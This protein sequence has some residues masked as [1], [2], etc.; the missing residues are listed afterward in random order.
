MDLGG[1]CGGCVGRGLGEDLELLLKRHN[2]LVAR[3]HGLLELSNGLCVT[4]S[5]LRGAHI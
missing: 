1:G 3:C 5:V 4:G 2:A